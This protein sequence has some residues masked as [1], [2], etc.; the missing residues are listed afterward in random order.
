MRTSYRLTVIALCLICC[1][2]SAAPISFEGANLRLDIESSPLQI[3]ISDIN[4]RFIC[5]TI[6]GG[7]WFR[8][9]EG[10]WSSITDLENTSQKSDGSI[11]L[12]CRNNLGYRARIDV[13]LKGDGV[14]KLKFEPFEPSV[15]VKVEFEASNSNEEAFFGL[16]EVWN[17]SLNQRGKKVR[18]WVKQGTPDECAYVPFLIS[19]TGYGIFVDNYRDGIF[20]VCNSVQDAW[21]FSF[22]DRSVDFYVLSG[23][24]PKDVVR[25][26]AEIT[27]KPPVP[28]KWSLLPWKW[29][30]R[31]KTDREIYDD[32]NGMLNNNI[33]LGVILADNPWQ[34]YG[35]NSFEFDPE[36]FRD[37]PRLIRNLAKKDVRFLVWTSPF[38]SKGVPNFDIARSRGYFIIDKYGKPLSAD[39][40]FYIDLTNPEAYNWWKQ[41]MKKAIRLGIAGMKL[42]RGQNIPVEA[43]FYDGS[44]GAEMHNKYALL[45]CKVVYEALNEERPHDFTI[46][47]RAGCAR[48]QVYSLG[49]W[50][51][52]LACNFSSLEGLGSAIIAGLSAGLAGF[53]N[54][55]SDI[56]GFEGRPSKNLFIRWAQFG[57]FSPI[58]QLHA[59]NAKDIRNPENFDQQMT[60][61]YRYYATLHSELIP[62]IYSH[63]IIANETGIPIMRPLFLEF[64]NDREAINQNFEYMFGP[65]I[66]VAPIYEDKQARDVYLPK[67][68]WFDYWTGRKLIGPITI[69]QYPC[70]IDRIPIFFRGGAIIPMMVRND[71]T[72]HKTLPK[73]AAC[74]TILVYPNG[75]SAV[76]IR[77]KTT[78]FTV[79]CNENTQ[80]ISIAGK[81]IN[82]PVS[83]CIRAQSKPLKVQLN[84]KHL[85]ESPQKAFLGEKG[86]W[87]FDKNKGRLIVH[88]P[89]GFASIKA[90]YR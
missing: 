11:S 42:D 21:S 53:S 71:V 44:T 72:G 40:Q 24:T 51:G 30:D 52:D 32:V 25:R 76:G 46:L 80:A 39:G 15:E 34:R 43:V 73:S 20:D 56:G 19:S 5:S 10:F 6:S 3:N 67:G 29:R 33:P 79:E 8:S 77:D 45:Y 31:I 50:P 85:K 23:P 89:A 61:I 87:W 83:L 17:G 41:E 86:L 69:K 54:W 35:M 82:W 55:G 90:F 57:A 22:K 7:F 18:M 27:G 70:P 48:S 4:G 47:P 84:G 36:L 28:P 12:L 59:K 88:A 60:R 38:T 63:A 65:D 75:R 66:L 62:Y 78:K 64:P 58:M 68:V 2:S 81:N 49:K 74:A 13:E 16:G 14:L 37:P 9:P 26:Y 1:A